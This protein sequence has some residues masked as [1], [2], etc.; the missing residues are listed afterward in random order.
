MTRKQIILRML[1]D[2]RLLDDRARGWLLHDDPDPTRQEWISGGFRPLYFFRG[3]G[4]GGDAAGVRMR[5]LRRDHLVPIELRRHKWQYFSK[6]TPI[7]RLAMTP[8]EIRSYDWDP[9]WEVPFIW[10]FKPLNGHILYLP[11]IQEDKVGQLTF[12]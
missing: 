6:V 10:Q 12:V 4:L 3:P 1:I 2:S 5:E 7:Y 11:T 9:A 8:E